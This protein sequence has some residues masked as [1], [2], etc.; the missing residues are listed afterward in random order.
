MESDKWP[1]ESLPEYTLSW[2]EQQFGPEYA[3][4]IADILNKY[5]NTTAGAN[6]RVWPLTPT[7]W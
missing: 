2:A 7:A 4:D 5:T 3:A 1:A 6:P